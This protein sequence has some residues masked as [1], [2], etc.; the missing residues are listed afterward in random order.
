MNYIPAYTIKHKLQNKINIKIMHRIILTFGILCITL[1]AMAQT[2]T[3]FWFAAPDISQLHGNNGAPNFLHI[4]AITNTTVTS[5]VTVDRPSDASFT[6][7]VFTLPPGASRSIQLDNLLPTGIGGI[8]VTPGIIQNEGFHIT[9]TPGQIVAFYELNNQYNRDIFPLKGMNALGTKFTVTTQNIYNNSGHNDSNSGFVI[10]A[11]ED[12]TTVQVNLPV[13]VNYVNHIGGGL[14]TILL[15]RAGDAYAFEVMSDAAAQHPLGVSVTSVKPIAI[16]VY[17][18]SMMRNAAMGLGGCLDTYGDQIVPDNLLGL[19]Y[20]VMK[21][22]LGDPPCTSPNLCRAEFAI[23]TAIENGTVVDTGGVVLATLNAGQVLPIQIVNRYTSITGSNPIS[24]THITGTG[25]GCEQGGALL[26]TTDGCTGSYNVTFA[27]STPAADNF[28]L[29]IMIRD[30]PDP[31]ISVIDS[32]VLRV[33]GVDFPVPS[34]FFQQSSD[35]LFWYLIDDWGG[36]QTVYNWIN[37]RIPSGSPPTVATMINPAARFHLGVLHGGRSNGAKYGYFSDYAGSSFSAGIGGATAP[38]STRYCSLDPFQLVG[39]GGQSY[40]WTCTYPDPAL[41]SKISDVKAAAPFFD[42]DEAGLYKFNVRISGECD[43]TINLPMDVRVLLGPISNFELSKTE[44]CSPM[45]VTITNTT[46]SLADKMLWSFSGSSNVINQD[47]IPRTFNKVF[48]NNTDTI[49][50]HTIELYSYGILNSCPHSLTRT[51]KVKPEI[52]AGFTVDTTKG[53]H[54]V[55]VNF[56]N[57]SSGHINSTSFFWDF[58]DNTQSFD[59]LPSH[60]FNNFTADSINYYVELIAKSPL[61]CSDTTDTIITVYPRVQSTFSVDTNYGCSP[62]TFNLSPAGSFGVDTLEWLINDGIN[63]YRYTRFDLTSVSHTHRDTTYATGPD[64]LNVMLVGRNKFG[65]ISNSV[66]R[67]LIVFPEIIS[68]LSVDKNIVCDSVPVVF[69]NHSLGDSLKFEWNFGDFTYLQDST[70]GSHQKIYLNRN[71]SSIQYTTTLKAISEYKCVSIHDTTVTVHPYL[72][73]GF[74][75]AYI[76]NCSPL[77]VTFN[78]TSTRVSDYKWNMGDGT[79]YNYDTT[80]FTHRYINSQ[81]LSDTT[82]YIQLIGEN[83]EGCKDTS[84][85]SVFLYQPVIAN[86]GISDS[87]GC[88]P[89]D[90]TISDSSSGSSLIYTWEFGDGISSTNPNPSFNKEFNNFSANDT[91]YTVTLLVKNLAG[92]DSVISRDVNVLAYIDADFSLPVIDSCSPLTPRFTNLSSPGSKITKW[93]FDNGD[94]INTDFNPIPPTYTNTTNVETVYNVSLV[95]YGAEDALHIACADTH[96]I[97]VTVF[98]E[99]Q[100]SFLLSDTVSCQ[101]L[102]SSITNTSTPATGTNYTWNI[103]SDFYSPLANPDDLNIPNL[104]ETDSTHTLWLYGST[105]YGCRDTASKQFTVHSLVKAYFTMDK[106]A[107]CSGDS[108]LIDKSGSRGGIT[109]FFWDYNGEFSDTNMNNQFYIKY[110]NPGATNLSK[111]VTLRVENSAGCDS[112]WTEALTVYPNV[113]AKFEPDFYSV[114]FPHNTAFTN[115]STNASE[116]FWDFGDGTTSTEA[117]PVHLYKNLSPT[118]NNTHIVKLTARSPALCIDSIKKPIVIY[119]KPAANF[120]FPVSVDCPPFIAEMNN[121]ST[122]LNLNYLWNFANEGSSTSKNASYTFVNDSNTIL[123]KPVTLTITSE[124]NC[125]DTLTKFLSVFPDPVVSFEASVLEGCSPLHIDF[126]G[127]TK[128]VLEMQWYIDN[129]ITFSTV[130]GPSYRFENELPDNKSHAI[131]FWGSSQYGCTDSLEKTITIFP[132]PV[133]EFIPEPSPTDYDTELDYTNIK[134]YNETAFLENWNYT[135]S[136]GDGV[137]NNDNRQV[138][139]YN[140]GYLVWGDINNNNQI[141]VQLIA[142]N[143]DR[144]EC[145][146]TANHMLIINPPLPQVDLAEDIEGCAPYTINFGSITKYNYEN[147]YDW[148]FGMTGAVSNLTTPTYTFEEPGV[149]P[150]K[151]TVYGDGGT[152]YDVKIV[153]VNPKPEAA[154]SFSDSLV[155]DSS[156]TKGYDWIDFYNH[157]TFASI[158]RWYFDSEDLFEDAYYFDSIPADSYLRE[159]RWA[160]PETGKYYVTLIA[161]SSKGCLDTL[162]NYA[163]PIVVVGEG[164]ISFPTGFFLNPNTA[165]PNEYDTD[166]RS[167]NLYLFYP[168]NVGVTKYKLEVYNKWGVLL[169]ETDDVNRGWNGYVDGI[170]AKQD[171]YVWRAKGEYS[172]GQKFSESGDVTL[173]RTEVNIESN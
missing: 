73:A 2:D 99:L 18:D 15:P 11:S 114:C 164:K 41:T 115:N 20:R 171:V 35:G 166:Q 130:S 85:K 81:L 49:Q 65:C 6:P 43:A 106:P 96:I 120:D 165:P 159:P 87:V 72:N 149:Y 57:T 74:G 37:N 47:T 14:Q 152:N 50:T 112:S 40:E 107:I 26:P 94:P 32:F 118:V 70:M 66:A 160:Y 105:K 100:A 173:I 63:N 59:S 25:G 142:Y 77:D 129:N 54:P 67:E 28:H 1:S 141:P 46:D 132:N 38:R 150:V 163:T 53:C 8:E 125:K 138:N 33:N 139:D 119:A 101:P 102:I 7:I 154:F 10:V 147:Q 117:A 134:F 136:Y 24:V 30:N 170:P 157:S 79:I 13:G 122:G 31:A 51:I 12:S 82:F 52:S 34:T 98:P 64:T 86:F 97:P 69:S 22:F 162:K 29:N 4:S 61:N 145:N 131:K 103:N 168:K 75:L 121:E 153:T 90:I 127:T 71:N 116:Y 9:S 3:E 88:A 27:H 19:N 56:D 93:N 109:K 161:E 124:N 68:R 144:T 110:N 23:V 21:G 155:Y 16:T 84:S 60:T 92:C 143:K 55:D 83:P 158:Y 167:G 151:L 45:N 80:A 89:L 169:F 126:T 140:Y 36:T 123:L 148:N 62:F 172:N 146:D 156:Q 78:N 42:P 135:W 76:N 133:A 58:G 128:N 111:Y 48:R 91:T 39:A 17:D 5:T 44:G 104:T 95:T 113:T 108:F 137:V